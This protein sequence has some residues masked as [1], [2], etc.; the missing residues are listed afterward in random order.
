MLSLARCLLYGHKGAVAK[1]PRAGWKWLAGAVELD[2]EHAMA[3]MAI[4][5][6]KRG[7]KVDRT[8]ARTL[9]EKAANHDVGC[10]RTWLRKIRRREV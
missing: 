9:F 1:H 4:Q 5:L 7:S 3:E 8:E 2:D 10:A 6:W